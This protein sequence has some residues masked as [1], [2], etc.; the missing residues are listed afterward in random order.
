MRRPACP[1]HRM[2]DR[3]ERRAWKKPR[4]A[5]RSATSY[6][7]PSCPRISPRRH[8]SRLANARPRRRSAP[9]RGPA[10]PVP[11]ARSRSHRVNR[12]RGV[13]TRQAT[14]SGSM[15]CAIKTGTESG[16]PS[17]PGSRGPARRRSTRPP[18]AH[19][20]GAGCRVRGVAV[21]GVCVKSDRTVN[22]GRSAR[23]GLPRTSIPFSCPNQREQLCGLS[24]LST[25]DYLHSRGISTPAS[26]GSKRSTSRSR[27]KHML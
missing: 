25:R 21:G 26:S 7:Q 20:R 2:A 17:N 3:Q 23:A 10:R 24:E 12:W 18:G 27:K 1:T 13:S 6:G 11:H 9:A 16:R 5:P 15:V 14:C 8:R 19:R 22:N 4:F